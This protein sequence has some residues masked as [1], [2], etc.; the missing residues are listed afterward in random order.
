MAN[1]VQAKNHNL[2]FVDGEFLL[3]FSELSPL[4]MEDFL[5]CLIDEIISL[6][7]EELAPESIDSSSLYLRFSKDFCLPNDFP[8]VNQESVLASY[9]ELFRYF[10]LPYEAARKSPELT[11][12]CKRLNFV[13]SY[14][15]L[16][17]FSAVG[18][19]LP[20]GLRRRISQSRM[21]YAICLGDWREVI[22]TFVDIVRRKPFGKE[23]YISYLKR[24]SRTIKK[25][26][27]SP[28][29]VE[30]WTGYYSGMEI[31]KIILNSH[32]Q[33]L[34]FIDLRHQRVFDLLS[35]LPAG[36]VLDIASNTGLFSFIAQR[37]GHN[38]LAVDHDHGAIDELYLS[39]KEMSLNVVP[40]VMSFHEL[41]G[42]R[43]SRFCSDY[44]LA[45]GLT[46]HLVL[47]EGMEWSEIVSVLSN[48]CRKI[49]ITDFK[50]ST[51]ARSER[52]QNF[53]TRLEHYDL[54]KFIEALRAV[55]R[56]VEVYDATGGGGRTI[57]RC[58]R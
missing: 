21:C 15:F 42:G 36:Q 17:V 51:G 1:L 5:S 58:E 18:R 28:R 31:K 32:W 43:G 56:S 3:R 30:K 8:V 44:C 41:G 54:N 6:S 9:S 2:K 23:R 27:K 20:A 48:V 50:P 52:L 49:L 38:V 4:M 22:A 14:E 35:G 37:A 10:I 57:L 55:F 46:H 34:D 12:F 26:D 7:N 24:Y 39:V 11:N 19:C 45:L 47:V 16:T 33:R 29:V 25:R 53:S 13:E 40:A